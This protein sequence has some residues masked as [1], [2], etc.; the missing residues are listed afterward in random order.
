M[1][2]HAW[3]DWT[4]GAVVGVSVLVGL[5]RG[6]VFEMMSL[7][8]WLVAYFVAGWAAPQVAPHVPIGAAGGALNHSAALV[9]A[10]VVTLLAWTLLAKMVRW[11]VSSTPLTWPDRLLGAVFGLVRG[12][13]LL[14]LVATV[15][16]LT[17][18][19]QSPLWQSS[20]AAR[21]L[22]AAVQG[23]KPLLPSSLA[24]WLPA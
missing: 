11:V 21:W 2:E 9:L 23:V 17:P 24:Q 22:M 20:S 7:A 13:V 14:M 5:W 19:A 10:F 12:G 16:A 1:D 15:V 3:V 18:A 6:L 8:G 4:L